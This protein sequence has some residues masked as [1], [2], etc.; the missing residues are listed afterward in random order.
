MSN[1]EVAQRF[2]AAMHQ[3]DVDGLLATLADDFVGHAAPGMPGGLGGTYRGSRE[4][5][6]KVWVPVYRTSGA[7]PY[8][9]ELLA[10]DDGRVVAIGEYRGHT[11]AGEPFTASF[12]HVF[13]FADN[14]IIEL[15]QITDTRSWLD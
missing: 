11:P 9:G 5:L 1:I 6:E 4:M 2:Y 7:M 3:L 14:R 10:V 12:A 13:R 8:P 15:R